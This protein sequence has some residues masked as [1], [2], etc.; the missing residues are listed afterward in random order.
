MSRSGEKSRKTKETKILARIEM[1]GEGMSRVATGLPFFDHMLT[2]FAAHGLFDLEIEAAGDLEV[3]GHHTVEDVGLVLGGAIGKALGDKK[4]IVRFGQAF[5][6]M[7][8]ALARAVID[9]SGRP[10]LA[11]RV[12]VAQERV[13]SFEA[14]L[15][16][17]FFQGLV[18]AS[19]MTL[20][21]DAW[22]GR[23]AHHVIEAVFKAFGRALDQASALDPR[24]TDVPS[25]KG[26]L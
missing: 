15:V 9:L 24:R 20:H 22:H 12:E 3:D 4:G 13:G 16:A 7:D 23:S 18:N 10:V 14:S 2:L 17:E 1:D 11:F 19:R 25:T 6:P 26:V 5:A 8:E 21:L